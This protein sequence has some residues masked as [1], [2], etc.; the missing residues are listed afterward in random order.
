[1]VISE[2][3]P[4]N[5]WFGS[6]EKFGAHLKNLVATTFIAQSILQTELQTMSHSIV[7]FVQKSNIL[8]TT[9]F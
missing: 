2:H 7:Q 1:M 5:E 4:M 6:F 9:H 8:Y 3:V